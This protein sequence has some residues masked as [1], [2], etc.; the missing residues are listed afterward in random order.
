M[1]FFSQNIM[2]LT[3]SPLEDKRRILTEKAR[4]MANLPVGFSHGEG[5]PVNQ[6]A[7]MCA[8]NFINLASQLE[9]EADVFP[10]LDGGCAVAFYKDSDKIEVSISPEGDQANLIYERGIG[11]QFEDVIPPMEN[12]GI[13]EIMDQALKLRGLNKWKLSASSISGT[14]TA[15]LEGFE[16]SSARM[17]QNQTHPPLLLTEEAGSQYLTLPVPA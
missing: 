17:P 15:P 11:F 10:N 2:L 8:E 5:Q 12:V 7:I 1:S 3:A 6:I 4:Q 9:L 13:T 14:L 16:I